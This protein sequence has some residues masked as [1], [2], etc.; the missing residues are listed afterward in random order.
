MEN[1]KQ[2]H[3]SQ[4]L[5]ATGGNL[6]VLPQRAAPRR[7]DRHALVGLLPA[8]R[9][10]HRGLLESAAHTYPLLVKSANHQQLLPTFVITILDAAFSRPQIQAPGARCQAFLPTMHWRSSSLSDTTHSMCG[11]RLPIPIS[12][13]LIPRTHTQT[14]LY[15]PGFGC[16]RLLHGL[17]AVLTLPPVL[18]AFVQRLLTLLLPL[19]CAPERLLQH[20]SQSSQCPGP[21]RQLRPHILLPLPASTMQSC[22]QTAS[23]DAEPSAV[24]RSR[25]P[26]PRNTPAPLPRIPAPPRAHAPPAA[27]APPLPPGP[28]LSR[29]LRLGARSRLLPF[30]NSDNN[31]DA[32]NNNYSPHR[33]CAP[34][35]GQRPAWNAQRPPICPSRCPETPRSPGPAE[36][37][38]RPPSAPARPQSILYPSRLPRTPVA[39]PHQGSRPAKSPSSAL[40]AL[41]AH[42]ETTLALAC[43]SGQHGA[44]R[45]PP[46]PKSARRPP[47]TRRL[48]PTGPPESPHKSARRPRAPSPLPRTPWTPGPQEP[49]ALLRPA[50][51]ACRPRGRPTPVPIPA[52]PRLSPAPAPTPALARGS[53]AAR[54]RGHAAPARHRPAARAGRRRGLRAPERRAQ[55]SPP[56]GGA[57]AVWLSLR[58]R[59]AARSAAPPRLGP[60]LH[61]APARAASGSGTR[62][63]LR[64]RRQHETFPP[65]GPPYPPP[66][67]V[68][69][70]RAQGCLRHGV[71][72]EVRM[73][74]R[75]TARLT[76]CRTG[77]GGTRRTSGVGLDKVVRPGAR[78]SEVARSWIGYVFR[79][80]GGSFGLE[81][82]D[83]PFQVPEAAKGTVGSGS[84]RKA[85]EGAV[86]RDAHWERRSFQ[87]RGGA[88]EKNTDFNQIRN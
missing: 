54:G 52:R 65:I 88:E 58:G 68:R 73:G 20:T 55:T 37:P 32:G 53:A 4:G 17:Q 16:Y 21:H 82:D 85:V 40:W 80:G 49:A 47:S 27:P 83:W 51:K 25:L 56:S 18:P 35:A 74:P 61:R 11:L 57:A 43:P 9:P 36:A 75:E 2:L 10:L 24:S 45:R 60:S 15:F 67:L 44:P 14:A 7:G 38:R 22:T 81:H 72:E 71:G 23:K 1:M 63:R 26:S 13:A 39:A 3:S 48:P 28:R 78:V 41:Q 77:W 6:D 46:T 86:S 33:K 8:S 12:R 76:V 62:R 66:P 30:Q 19:L 29:P 34:P 64:R 59:R 50:R 84:G 42:P 31:R 70:V 69:R 79:K 87:P 5:A